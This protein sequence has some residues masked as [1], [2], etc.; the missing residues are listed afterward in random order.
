VSGF[1]GYAGQ[2]IGLKAANFGYA[3]PAALDLKD[4]KLKKID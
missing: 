3:A 1:A 2:A 4:L